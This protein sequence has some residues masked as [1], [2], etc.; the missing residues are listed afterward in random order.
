M[1]FW[2]NHTILFLVGCALFPRITLLFFSSISFGFWTILGWI[3]APH[4]L[5]AILATMLYWGS[6]PILVIIAW[7]FA[8]V[9]SGGESR[10]VTSGTT[11]RS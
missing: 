7:F 11:A 9:G 5:V 10:V 8:L 6:N 4:L 1:D 2:S 3:F